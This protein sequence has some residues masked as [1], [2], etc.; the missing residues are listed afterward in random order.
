MKE[1][2]MERVIKYMRAHGSITQ[3]DAIRDLGDTRLSGKVFS[4]K[5][6]GY[7]IWSVTETGQDRFG[8]P[9]HWSRYFLRED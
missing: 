8:T 6:K 4:L 3:Q 2:K 5:K 9:T 1:T 7:D